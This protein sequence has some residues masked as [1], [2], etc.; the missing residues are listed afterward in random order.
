MLG[1]GNKSV[2]D[3]ALESKGVTSPT[4]KNETDD[5]PGK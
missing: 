4:L 3:L 1:L 5:I 2:D